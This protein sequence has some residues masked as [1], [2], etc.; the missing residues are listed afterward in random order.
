MKSTLVSATIALCL[1]GG[2]ALAE[3]PARPA[4]EGEASGSSDVDNT[5][6]NVRDRDGAMPT[7][8]DQGNS[9]TDIRITSEIRAAIVEND[10][11]SMNAHNVKI[12]TRDGVVVLRGPVED[13]E[14]K[15]L[16][17]SIASD[18]SG[19]KRVDDQLEIERQD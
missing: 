1:A 8:F 18:T 12:I 17:S 4:T 13:A 19:V 9:E 5:G 11:L 16:I 15:T 2:W 3:Q 10:E 6:R 14:E 7:P